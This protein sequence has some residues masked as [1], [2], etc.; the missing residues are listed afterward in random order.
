MRIKRYTEMK[1]K[2]MLIERG[3]LQ[4]PPYLA[5]GGECPRFY[6]AIFGLDA[7]VCGPE[8]NST[9]KRV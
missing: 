2:N 8:F 4:E 9:K 1:Y 7:Y 6:E 3:A 5:M